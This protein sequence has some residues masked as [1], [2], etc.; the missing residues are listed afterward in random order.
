M[1]TAITYSDIIFMF[2]L[3]VIKNIKQ[4]FEKIL[5]NH[6]DH[7]EYIIFITFFTLLLILSYWNLKY[8]Y[9]GEDKY[10]L[11]CVS[12]K[13]LQLTLCNKLLIIMIS[14][15]SIFVITFNIFPKQKKT[16]LLNLLICKIL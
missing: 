10:N 2:I 8:L 5:M 15:L 13:F 12:D 1:F 16:E 6:I 7:D 9:C 14:I 11:I 4:Y 3:I